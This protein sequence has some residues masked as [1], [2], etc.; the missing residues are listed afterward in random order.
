[1]K[2]LVLSPLLPE[3]PSD[4]DRLRLFYFLNELSRRHELTLLAFRQKDDNPHTPALGALCRGG[5]H[6]LVMPRRRQWLNAGLAFFSS[7]PANI[8]SYDSRKML[9]LVR[10]TTEKKAFDGVL[11]YRLRMAPYALYSGLA[12][13]VLDFTDS[14]HLLFQRRAEQEKNPLKR[15]LWR[16]EAKKLLAAEARYAGR[17]RATFINGAA[18]SKSIA[19]VSGQAPQVAPNGVDNFW[20]KGPRPAR[21]ARRMVFVGNLAYVPNVLGLRWFC[22]KVLPLLLERDSSI[23]LLVVG[24]NAPANMPVSPAV[25]YSGFVKDPRALV[26]SAAVAVCPLSVAAGRQN[27]IMEAFALGVPVVATTMTAAGVEAGHRRE[28]LAADSAEDF[29][30]SCWQLMS[31][32]ALAKKISAAAARFVKKKYSWKRSAGLIEKALAKQKQ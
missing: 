14:M 15:I 8:S 17:F 23:Q 24:G 30:E 2:L 21:R 18:D 16:R 13:R 32:P 29:S 28:L 19:R 9:Q 7:R 12:N 25:T 22:A 20:Y 31:R 27:K 1:M 6:S 10:A 26:R 4:G 3:G 11:A 5:V